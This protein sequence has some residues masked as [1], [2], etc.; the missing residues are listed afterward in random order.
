MKQTPFFRWEIWRDQI[1]THELYY[2][3]WYRDQ[4]AEIERVGGGHLEDLDER[5][6]NRRYMYTKTTL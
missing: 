1:N 3:H 5:A 2:A 6:F 4:S